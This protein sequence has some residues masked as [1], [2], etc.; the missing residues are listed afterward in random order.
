MTGHQADG[1]AAGPVSTTI[2]AR[3]GGIMTTEVGA[4]TGEVE[5]STS[6]EDGSPR[7][8]VRY[9]GAEEWYT[10]EGLPAD[11]DGA[12]V[13]SAHEQAV[14]ALS[15]PAPTAPAVDATDPAPGTAPR[16]D[17]TDPAAG[18]FGSALGG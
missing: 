1:H 9:A 15:T 4:I 12:V 10:P 8:R 7:T 5:V 18:G 16:R 6:L 11:R 14:T 2:T 13:A 3:E 17:A